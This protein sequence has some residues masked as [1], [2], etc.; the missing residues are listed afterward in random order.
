MWREGRRDGVCLSDG[1]EESE[2]EREMRGAAAADTHAS[3]RAKQATKTKSKRPRAH[4]ARHV[5]QRKVL[6][7]AHVH[8]RP[9]LGA[10]RAREGREKEGREGREGEPAAAARVV[11]R[12]ISLKPPRTPFTHPKSPHEKVR[13]ADFCS[14]APSAAL[15]DCRPASR[16]SV[17][18]AGQTW[19]GGRV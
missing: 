19:G 8:H 2:R 17:W 6:G 9:A 4:R 12:L 7:Q 10:A 3:P 5:L 15:T 16:S 18:M 11:R 1:G 13:R 14:L